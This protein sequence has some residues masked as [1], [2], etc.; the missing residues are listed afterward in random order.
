MVQIQDHKNNYMLW[1]Q[2]GIKC[3]FKEKIFKYE[4]RW[5]KKAIWPM[6][7]L[8]HIC[9]YLP[10]EEDPVFYLKKLKSI[11]QEI[12][13]TKFDWN[14]P[15]GSGFYQIFSPNINTYKNDFPIVAPTHPW[16]P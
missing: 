16:G 9:D 6:G 13:Y 4:P 2:K 5:L 14:L 8:L 10:Y 12:I 11:C 3:I 15:A 1:P 7:I